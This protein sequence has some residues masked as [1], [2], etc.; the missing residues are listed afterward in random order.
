[1]ILKSSVAPPSGEMRELQAQH[2]PKLLNTSS[3]LAKVL[4]SFCTSV[5]YSTS[6]DWVADISI[7]ISNG[8]V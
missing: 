7:N 2:Y 6:P 5:V 1:M 4:M 8:I 3:F